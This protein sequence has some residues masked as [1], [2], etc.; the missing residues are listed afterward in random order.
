[1]GTT[2]ISN[3][4]DGDHPWAKW[5]YQNVQVYGLKTGPLAT[6]RKEE[7]QLQKLIKDKIELGREGVDDDDD[8]KFLLKI[9]LE[10][11]DTTSGE[12]QEYWLLAILAARDARLLWERLKKRMV[13]TFN[14][15]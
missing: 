9:N 4:I 2:R 8:G 1:M 5:L 3:K 12:T 7:L 11:L 13:K 10:G 15:L 6:R 14:S